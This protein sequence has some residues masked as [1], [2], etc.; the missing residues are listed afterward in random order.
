MLNESQMAEVKRMK[1]CFPF[2]I[3]YAAIKGDEFRCAAVAT[4]RIPNQL[5]RDG[6]QVW[7]TA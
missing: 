2:R 3:V 1:A 5:A 4:K 6:W 7:V